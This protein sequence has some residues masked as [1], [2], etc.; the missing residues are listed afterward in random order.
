MKFRTYTRAE[1]SW[2]LKDAVSWEHG[3]EADRGSMRRVSN[4]M[5]DSEEESSPQ[6][7]ADSNSV[8]TRKNEGRVEKTNLARQRSY[9][10]VSLAARSKLAGL[11]H[12]ATEAETEGKTD[13]KKV[14]D[15]VFDSVC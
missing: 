9:S 8:S 13:Y 4:K 12:L 2:Q 11:I 14:A 6:D 5:A 10:T 15:T 1:S 3:N 7:N